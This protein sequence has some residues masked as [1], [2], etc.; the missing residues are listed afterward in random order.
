[1]QTYNVHTTINANSGDFMRVFNAGRQKMSI[2]KIPTLIP[3][4]LFTT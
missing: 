2:Q 3:G 4:I 1:M